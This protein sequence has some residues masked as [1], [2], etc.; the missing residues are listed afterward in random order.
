MAERMGIAIRI[1]E[2]LAEES[3]PGL[4]RGELR[5]RLGLPP[6]TEIGARVRELRDYASYGNFDVRVEHVTKSEVRYYLLGNERERAKTFLA[7]GRAA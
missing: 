4:T 7:R 3:F 1:L 2:V 6:D 5:T